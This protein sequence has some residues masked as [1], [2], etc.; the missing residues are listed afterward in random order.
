M[1]VKDILK[2]Y[3]KLRMANMEILLLQLLQRW[4]E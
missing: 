3:K 1:L 4:L 2:E